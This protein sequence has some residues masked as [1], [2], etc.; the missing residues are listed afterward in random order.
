MRAACLGPDGSF[1]HR[2]ALV[3]AAGCELV[4][5]ESVEAVLAALDD[6]SVDLAVAAYDS[7]AGPVE[8]VHE[9]VRTGRV[10]IEARH[11]LA[12]SFNLYRA[13]GDDAPLEGV[14]GHD[15]A[16]GQIEAFLKAHD[17]KRE[18]LASNTLGLVL[19]RDAP[20]PGWGAAGPPGLENTYPLV[21]THQRLEG[22]TPNET[23]FVR[24][25]RRL[26]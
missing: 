20:R 3:L 12:V 23:V 10:E 2:A 24:L 9:A 16:L 22:E 14:F 19:M 25:A 7:A 11:G 8:A 1:T 13:P 15:K 18:A 26:P 6:G 5:M 17:L 4:L 21:V